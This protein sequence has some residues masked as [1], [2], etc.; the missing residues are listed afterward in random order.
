MSR[1]SGRSGALALILGC[2]AVSGALRLSEVVT[3]L[4]PQIAAAAEGE[5]AQADRA[6]TE[7]GP[8]AAADAPE[9]APEMMTGDAETG[10]KD[11]AEAADAPAGAETAEPPIGAPRSS[12][13][14]RACG[15]GRPSRSTTTPRRG[16]WRRSKRARLN[17]TPSARS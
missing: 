7:D 5:T 16:F 12:R 4:T 14:R 13:R 2:F 17:S 1:I 15:C 9:I 3:S 8:E 6:A 10:A 11:A